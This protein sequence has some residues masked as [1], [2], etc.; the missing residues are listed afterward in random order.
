MSTAT[1]RTY[2]PINHPTLGRVFATSDGSVFRDEPDARL[3][4][5]RSTDAA[6]SCDHGCSDRP[7]A[8]RCA[9]ARYPEARPM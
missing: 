2:R 6:S 5:D 9:F 3:Y 4:A 8:E 1:R 7:E